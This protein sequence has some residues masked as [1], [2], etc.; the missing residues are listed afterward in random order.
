MKFKYIAYDNE[1]KRISGVVNATNE[2][3]ARVILKDL[4]LIELKPIKGRFSF[5]IFSPSVS[6]KDISK[7]LFIIG[8]Y[9]KS[10]IPL[11]TVLE[12]SKKQIENSRLL[13]LLDKLIN[14][15][16]EGKSFYIALNNQNIVT[17][18]KYVLNAIK[19]S[20][21]NG[22]LASVLI[23]LSNFL[24][25]E[26]FIIS[27][28]TQAL[29]YPSIIVSVAFLI[30]GF[31]LINI[32]PKIVKIFHSMNEDLPVITKFVINLGDFLKE[33]FILIFIVLI[34]LSF[35]LSFLYK[36]VYKFKLFIHELLLYI[37]VIR[38]IIISK[39]LGRFSYL[40]YTLHSSGLNYVV[41]LNLASSIIE[42]EKIRSYFNKALNKVTEGK[43]FAI[44]LK[45]SGFNLDESFLEAIFLAEKTNE[46]SNIFKNISDIYF[47]ENRGRIN[48]L[49]SLIEP[50]LILFI[51]IAVGFI[52]TA[53]LLP[54][55]KINML[56]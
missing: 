17:F 28:T 35:V 16:R 9:L 39:E 8:M 30:V 22:R 26:D 19:I 46:I 18:P 7:F 56:K 36:K 20:E 23:E 41:S 53:M 25:E 3:E 6:K 24:K 44:S 4:L 37:P 45:N 50:I 47:E 51:G 14:E 29:I 1:G 21:E 48:T 5:D 13:N 55:F 38:N 27:K 2:N 10:G 12:L 54:M 31:M 11:V 52:V 33:N 42:N 34:L 15:I 43:D 40:L 32:V 49:L